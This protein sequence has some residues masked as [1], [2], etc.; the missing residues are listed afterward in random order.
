MSTAI[1]NRACLKDKALSRIGRNSS[2]TSLIFVSTEMS[3]S[4]FLQSPRICEVSRK[5]PVDAPPAC[6]RTFSV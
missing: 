4:G 5:A 3:W 6:P 1:S 2:R